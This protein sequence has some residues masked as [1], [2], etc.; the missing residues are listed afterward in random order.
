VEVPAGTTIEWVVHGSGAPP[1]R[2]EFRPSLA[3]GIRRLQHFGEDPANFP[4]TG[5]D[6]GPAGAGGA[7]DRART[8]GD[9]VNDDRWS[10]DEP[11]G[12]EP[13][14]QGDEALGDREQ[15]DPAFGE[16]LEVDPSLDPTLVVDE[17]ELEELGATLDD[18][19]TIATLEGGIDDPDGVG[20]PPTGSAPDDDAA[21]W[22]T[23]AGSGEAD[24]TTD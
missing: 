9:A 3:S 22:G 1:G 20:G 17:R 15:L 13:F 21:G 12:S 6:A 7:Y 2:P 24:A 10:P 11:S 23:E 5:E 18:P 19:E 4:L 16:D 14:E 8:T